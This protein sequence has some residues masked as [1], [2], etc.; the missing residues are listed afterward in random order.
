MMVFSINLGKDGKF[1]PEE[2][3]S[4]VHCSVQYT[5]DRRQNI[6]VRIWEG[7]FYFLSFFWGGGKILIV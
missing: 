6:G 1:L 4:E 3:V 5:C 2:L 7:S